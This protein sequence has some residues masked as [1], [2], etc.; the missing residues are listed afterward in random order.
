MTIE[1]INQQ[2]EELIRSGQR[3]K[4]RAVL[5]RLKGM[6]IPR[7]RASSLA[8][9]ARRAG[10]LPLALQIMSPIIRPKVTLEKEATDA[11]KAA[12][13]VILLG[14]GASTEAL[15]IL[16]NADSKN[17][18]VLLSL[19]FTHINRWDYASAIVYLKRY[20][21][22]EEPTSY[23][24]LIG[25]VNLAA[26]FVATG[27][28][29]EARP[30]LKGILQETRANNWMLLQK[31]ALEL[32]AQIAIQNQ[33]WEHAEQFLQEASRVG[34]ADGKSD[35]NDF[36]VRKW[37]AIAAVL[38]FGAKPETID[39]LAKVRELAL[40]LSHWETIRDCDYHRAIALKDPQLA[41]SVY[42]GTPYARFRDRLTESSSSWL[43]I[44]DEYV[45]NPLGGVSGSTAGRVFNIRRGEEINGAATLKPG[46][47]LHCA[48]ET[49]T[50]DFYRPFLVGSLHSAVFPGEHFNPVSSPRRVAF[51]VHRLRE[52]TEEHEI[53]VNIVVNKD[54]Y[55]LQAEKPFAFLVSRSPVSKAE[56]DPSHYLVMLDKLKEQWGSRYFTVTQ[57]SDQ[58]EISLRT[59]RY[60][61][62]WAAEKKKLKRI[63]T[64]R[65][66]QYKLG[67]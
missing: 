6:Q 51:L 18:E 64:G 15:E 21:A 35:L 39:G 20:L 38:K 42:F 62:K 33:E 7:A 29:F 8:T 57:V 43:A 11:E 58:F 40:S 5:V 14:L 45:W 2:A 50:S 25:R 13:A 31:N 23:Q 60:F 19:A 24:K 63:G 41:L 10:L 61:L 48:L 30:L 46:K 49:L 32:C 55:R 16:S 47:G 36:F 44:P 22:S 28:A 34:S 53:P 9:L 37:Q 66:T 59:A 17:A 1:E 56:G 27:N 4:A 67:R 26:S 65:A 12:Y 52:W 54:G 3:E